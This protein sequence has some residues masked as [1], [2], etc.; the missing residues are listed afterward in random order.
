MKDIS[1]YSEKLFVPLKKSGPLSAYAPCT[2]QFAS[3]NY[4]KR[5]RERERE[6]GGKIIEFFPF[7]IVSFL[8][9]ANEVA[10]R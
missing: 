4:K 2:R 3:S 1:E 6:T 10:G 7:E 8:P 5:E 9:P